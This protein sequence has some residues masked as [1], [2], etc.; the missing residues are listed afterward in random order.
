MHVE[1]IRASIEHKDVF[2][3]LMQLYIYDFSEFIKCDVEEDGLFGAY[4]YL[5]SYWED[6]SHR[7][8]YIIKQEGKYAGFIL[9]RFVESEERNFFT[10]AEFFVMK[11]YRKAGIGRAVAKQVFNSHKGSWEVFQMESN[12]PAQLFW[13]KVIDEYTNGQFSNRLGDGKR[14]QTFIS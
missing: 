12:R 13:N 7:F 9:V 3:N 6:E 11:K 2:K 4:P 5:D 8:P 1:C 10:I 14:I